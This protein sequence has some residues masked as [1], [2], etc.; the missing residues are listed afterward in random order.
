[1]KLFGARLSVPAFA[2]ALAAATLVGCEKPEA[3]IAYGTKLNFGQN[4]NAAAIKTSGWNP[5]EENF[6]WSDG[7]SAVL[8]IPIAPTDRPVTLTV[9]MNS[10]FKAPELPAQPVTVSVNNTK[11]A[12]W[13]VS[14][15]ENFT[16]PIPENL[17]KAG[18]KLTIKFDLPK[19]TSPKVLGKGEDPRVLGIAVY[20]VELSTS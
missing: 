2:V 15:V 20:E 9:R 14:E 12:D 7:T 17:T 10:L 3:K 4:G 19:A 13:Q 16:A 6:T 18:G 1:M 11:I 5:A 8:D